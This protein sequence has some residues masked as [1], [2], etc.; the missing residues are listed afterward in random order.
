MKV[1]FVYDKYNNVLAFANPA[2]VSTLR[3]VRITLF[4]LTTPIDRIKWVYRLNAFLGWVSYICRVCVDQS[5]QLK[6]T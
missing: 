4:I 5:N 3:H 6:I 2:A 1:I